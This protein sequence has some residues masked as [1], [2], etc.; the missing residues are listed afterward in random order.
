M[1]FAACS[2]P[3]LG[4]ARE[5]A[6]GNLDVQVEPKSEVDTL[7]HALKT[8]ALKLKQSQAGIVGLI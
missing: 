6:Q 2:Q 8:M 4:R 7:G 5:I 3:S 1:A